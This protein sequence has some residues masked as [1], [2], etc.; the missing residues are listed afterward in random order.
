[1]R[2]TNYG[3]HMYDKVQRPNEPHLKEHN[4]E[5]DLMT[6]TLAVDL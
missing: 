1:M 6:L 4:K 2:I 5:L 3:R